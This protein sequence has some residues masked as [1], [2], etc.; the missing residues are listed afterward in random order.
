MNADV[1]NAFGH[2]NSERRMRMQNRENGE[3]F[4][5]LHSHSAFRVSVAYFVAPLARTPST[6]PSTSSAVVAYPH[7]SRYASSPNVPHSKN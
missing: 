2:R 7:T 6:N 4:F 3:A 5:I 1:R